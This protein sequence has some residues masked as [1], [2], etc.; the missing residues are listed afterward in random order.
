MKRFFYL[1]AWC[2]LSSA[3]AMPPLFFGPDN[4]L[5][6]QLT[7]HL[8]K[9]Q[10]RIWTASYT[11]TGRTIIAALINA[12]QRGVDVQVI[13]DQL[14]LENVRSRQAIGKLKRAG[15]PLFVFGRTRHQG[16][17]HHKFAVV[18][19]T[20][21]TGSMN[22]TKAGSVFNEENAIIL[23]TPA[24]VTSYTQHFVILKRRVHH[25][26]H[27]TPH[28]TNKVFFIPDH[29]KQ[30]RA[31]LLKDLATA[32]TRIHLATFEL[33][34][35]TLRDALIA[36]GTRGVAT[37][38]I[39][40][41]QRRRNNIHSQVDALRTAGTA[42]MYSYDV[43]NS[44]TLMH[45]KLAVIDDTVWLGSMNW[46]RSGMRRNQ[47]NMVRIVNAQLAARCV[48]HL[49]LLASRCKKIGNQRRFLSNN[50]VPACAGMTI[51]SVVTKN[52]CAPKLQRRLGSSY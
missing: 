21:W 36:A 25:L 39:V 11:V 45:H 26:P 34:S 9:A 1:L 7:T 20:V 24:V 17:M 22:W 38:I 5:A 43:H 31:T 8:K 3:T 2:C 4:H 32:R 13:T 42:T 47:E 40:D 28:T 29:H 46:T 23:D 12:K 19:N 52:A 15:I 30:L 16:L 27:R 18:D 37:T 33:T 35:K 41:G 49:S 44:R 48:A 10:K 6:Q 50:W 14:A 51:G